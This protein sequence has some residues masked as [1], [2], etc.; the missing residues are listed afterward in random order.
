MTELRDRERSEIFTL[1]AKHGPGRRRGIPSRLLAA[2]DHLLALRRLQEMYNAHIPGDPD[3]P[4][5]EKALSALAVEYRLS[6]GDMAKIPE[7]GPVIVCANH[8]F[9]GLEGLIL[10]AV[11][12]KIRQDVKIMANPLL[13]RIPELREA[14]IGTDPFGTDRAKQ[15][16]VTALRGCR[17]WLDQ[18]GMLVVFPA[19][20]VSHFRLSRWEVA[21]PA[22]LDSLPWLARNTGAAVLPVFFEGGNSPLF[23]CAGLL[24]PRLRTALLPRELLNKQGRT[25]GMKIGKA[26]SAGKIAE[27]QS[28]REV[29]EYLRLRTYMLGARGKH[30]RPGALSPTMRPVATQGDPRSIEEDIA[31]LPEEQLLL[32]SGVF[33]AF[34]ARADEIPHVLS[35]IGRLR[36]ITFRA[37]SEGT[38]RERDLDRFDGEYL[39]LFLWNDEKKEIVGAYRMGEVRGILDRQGTEGLYTSTLFSF[40]NGMFDRLESALEM[41]RS[42]VRPE[43]QKSF[44]ALL[45]LWKGIGGYLAAHPEHR[46]LFGPVSISREYSEVTRRLI[47]GSV[48]KY[49][50]L[51]EL[52]RMVRPLTPV[53][54]K[55]PRIRGCNR[56]QVSSLLGDLEEVASMIGDIDAGQ[57]DIPVLMKFYL[58]LGGRFVAFNRDPAFGDVID[59]LVVVDLLET[60]RKTLNRYMGADGAGRFLAHHA[61]RGRALAV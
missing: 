47:T 37:V 55:P 51:N 57:D 49:H 2:L 59:G 50:Y 54:L 12:R 56:S 14:V 4:F 21:D 60:P 61:E 19:G 35:E 41:G 27:R 30:Q 40:K 1:Q 33:R 3:T 38:G 58:N 32:S 18:G 28:D 39:H 48:R 8:P 29:V 36:E 26:I 20:E 46:I 17:R 24:H 11:L 34:Y 53:S 44:S 7:K 52:A 22:W 9:G 6:P 31:R 10:I 13:N 42:F 45:L 25:V 15:A 43:Y 16:N 5:A 23:H